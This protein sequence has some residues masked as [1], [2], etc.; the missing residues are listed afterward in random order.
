[1]MPITPNLDRR[2]ARA[3]AEF[4]PDD[5][6]IFNKF[7]NSPDFERCTTFNTLPV[8]LQSKVK[9]AEVKIVEKEGKL[10]DYIDYGDN[11]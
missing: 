4:D 9:E 7:L 8:D 10:P 6:L 2:L 5:R 1:M 3:I 11:K